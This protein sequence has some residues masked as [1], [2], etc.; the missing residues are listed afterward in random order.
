MTLLSFHSLHGIA[1]APIKHTTSPK[2]V[3]TLDGV[4]GDTLN[5][6]DEEMR[7]VEEEQR[8]VVRVQPMRP[9]QPVM[10]RLQEEDGG[11]YQ[12]MQGVLYDRK[13]VE[14]YFPFPAPKSIASKLIEKSGIKSKS[15]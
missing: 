7:D 5:L 15:C 3:V 4:D 9:V 12:E 10:V 8:N 2:F 13:H 1:P 11:I 6:E 14:H